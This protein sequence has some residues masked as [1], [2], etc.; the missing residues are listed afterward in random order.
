MPTLV[1]GIWIVPAW[2][3]HSHASVDHGTPALWHLKVMDSQPN[4]TSFAVGADYPMTP[5]GGDL[6]RL[7]GGHSTYWRKSKNVPYN[8]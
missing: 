8:S 4:A 7:L 2:R 5:L 6:Y 1:V 3:F